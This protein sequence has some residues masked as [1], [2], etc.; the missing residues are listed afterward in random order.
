MTDVV[1]DACPVMRKHGAAGQVIRRKTRNLGDDQLQDADVVVVE[2]NAEQPEHSVV[3]HSVEQIIECEQRVEGAIGNAQHGMEQVSDQIKQFSKQVV[4][5]ESGQ[6]ARAGDVGVQLEFKVGQQ[7][8]YTRT[9]RDGR[10]RCCCW[11]RSGN[12]HAAAVNIPAG[13]GPGQNIGSDIERSQRQYQAGVY[14]Q[15]H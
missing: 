11:E 3:Q 6:Y 8:T 15:I 1:V 2:L 5:D 14:I 4:R 10:Q 7:L 9:K 13:V 12:C